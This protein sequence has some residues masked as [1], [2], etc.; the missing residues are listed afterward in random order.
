MK[1]EADPYAQ[2]AVRNQR[3][4][5]ITPDWRVVVLIS[6]GTGIQVCL[7]R[8]ENESITSPHLSR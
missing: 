6:K 4:R 3:K 2:G 8:P 5:Q 1:Y 7:G